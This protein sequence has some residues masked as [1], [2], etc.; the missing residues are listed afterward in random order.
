MHLV[1]FIQ[2]ILKTVS[3]AYIYIMWEVV[4]LFKRWLIYL[5][6]GY[7][8][9]VPTSANQCGQNTDKYIHMY[10]VLTFVQQELKTEYLSLV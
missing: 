5:K 7:S 6:G 8:R 10:S 1:L 2:Y 4:N 3:V 9:P